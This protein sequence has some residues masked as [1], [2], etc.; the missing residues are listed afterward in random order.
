MKVFVPL[1]SVR[2]LIDIQKRKLYNRQISI[3][4]NRYS[5]CMN[6][7]DALAFLFF[8]SREDGMASL[9]DARSTE[10]DL[11]EKNAA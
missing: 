11:R 1:H 2:S 9:V 5:Q 8:Y 4:C 6:L 7:L 10:T 3:L